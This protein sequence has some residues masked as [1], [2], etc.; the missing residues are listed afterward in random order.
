MLDRERYP[1]LPILTL[2]LPGIRLYIVNSTH[3]IPLVQRQW[4]TLLFP[5]VTV[6][7]SQTAMGGSKEALA[8]IGGDMVSESGFLP[9][10]GK[11]IHPAL[12]P[13]P[14]LDELTLNA[15][16][17]LTEILDGIISERCPQTVNM[18]AWIRH[19]FL[20][21]TG[22]SVYGPQNP[23]RDPVNEADWLYVGLYSHPPRLWL[24][25]QM[26]WQNGY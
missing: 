12:S 13:G 10:F 9:A 23:L 4:R 19:E 11:A 2:R 6:R 8:I 5:P 17:V 24:W 22:D 26:R 7:A 15:V 20:M 14:D 21:A 18:F 3:L 25:F 16:R 1:N